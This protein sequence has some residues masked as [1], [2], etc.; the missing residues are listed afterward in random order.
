[1]LPRRNRVLLGASDIISDPWLLLEI[2]GPS[3][4]HGALRRCGAET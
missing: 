1:M 2:P 3:F 4:V